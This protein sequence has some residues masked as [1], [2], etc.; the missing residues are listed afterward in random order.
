VFS[1]QELYTFGNNGEGE[2]GQNDRVPRSSPVQLG[3]LTTWSTGDIGPNQ[4]RPQ[5]AA[6]STSNELYTFGNN[7]F[8]QLGQNDVT[9]RSSPVQVGALTNWSDVS[10]GDDFIAA[11]KTDG[12]LWTWGSNG[13]GK[14]GDGTTIRRSSPVQIGSDT[15]WSGVSAGQAHCLAVKANGTLWAWGNNDGQIGDNTVVQKSSPVQI[16]SNTNWT[17]VVA[18]ENT[19]FAKTTDGEWYVWG[20]NTTGIYGNNTEGAATVAS[21]PI[22]V[23]IA[24]IDWLEGGGQNFIVA[25]KTDGSLFAWGDATNGK[26]GNNTETP[27][28][29]SPIQVG[30]LTNWSETSCGQNF[31]L[32]TKTDG[33]L[34]AWGDNAN[35]QLGTNNRT[36]RSSPVQVGS[37]T[38][39]TKTR[40][41]V[42]ASLTFVGSTS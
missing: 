34:W 36:Y 7:Y 15:N 4:T 14:N 10:C 5:V 3:S 28:K 12:T 41:G 32:A 8:G 22:Q 16:G 29:S 20:A 25:V 23:P 11:I 42:E 27:N 21:S 39:W 18:V 37:D 26:L 9:F 19:S 38:N 13:N 17:R 24:D 30:S 40:S 2:L 35:G 31:V 1:G 6:I 33:T